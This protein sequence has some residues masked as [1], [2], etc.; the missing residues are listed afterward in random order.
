LQNSASSGGPV[1]VGDT[2][3]YTLAVT[4][5]GPDASPETVL[6]DEVPAGLTY[7]SDDGGCRTT[8]LPKVECDLGTLGSGEYRSVHLVTRVSSVDSGPIRDTATV[9]GAR[10]DPHPANNAATAETT[11]ASA[12]S[13]PAP[14]GPPTAG[15]EAPKS[16]KHHGHRKHHQ[17]KAGKSKLLLRQRASAGRARPSS[18]VVFTVTVWNKGDGDARKV[19]VCDAPGKGLTIL[20]T[21]PTVGNDPA[22]WHLKSLAAGAKRVFRVTARVGPLAASAL[23]RNVAWVGAANVKGVRTARAGVRVKP[24]PNTACGSSAFSLGIALRC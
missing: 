17:H 16:S 19:A 7:V 12:T 2:I 18:V 20:R 3:T 10:P 24:L 6:T 23:A 14:L 13:P 9:S 1:K 8:A 5:E 11:V 4:D 22:C 21:E 15:G